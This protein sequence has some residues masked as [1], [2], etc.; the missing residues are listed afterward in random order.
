M[1]LSGGLDSRMTTWVAHDMGYRNIVNICYSQSTSLDCQYAKDVAHFLGNQF[2]VKYLDEA[3]FV[4]EVEEVTKKN[5]GMGYYAG[6]TG[7]NQFLKFLNFRVL[8]LEHTGQLGDLI[9]GG[10]YLKSLREDTIDVNGIKYSNRVSCE[11][12]N[13]SGYEGHELMSLYL[14]GFQG[15]LSTHYIRS[16]YT[17]AVSPLLIQSL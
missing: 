14:R 12:I 16:N 2:Y 8:G 11:D 17:Y 1:D 13:V 9:V 7:G 3:S 15:A 6:I 4:R 10:G 5:F